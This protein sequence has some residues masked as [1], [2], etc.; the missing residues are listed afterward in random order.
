[1]R[2]VVATLALLGAVGSTGCIGNIRDTTTPRTAHEMLLVSTAAQ[3]AVR[4]YDAGP[5]KGRKV[6]LDLTLFDPIDKN[7]VQSSLRYHLANSGVILSDQA[8]E[9]EIVME[10]RNASLGLWDGDFVLGIPQLPVSAQGLPPVMLPP[11]YAFRRLSHQGFAKFQ[12]WLYDPKTKAYLGRSQDLW[13]TSYYNQWWFFG[14]GPFDGSNDVF[15]DM[16]FGNMVGM[17]GDAGDQEAEFK[18]GDT[19]SPPQEVPPSGDTQSPPR[20]D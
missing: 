9:C 14:I 11:L 20:D 1:M 7:Y 12:L 19:T 13:G 8:S 18:S 10:V 15:P 2:N 3:R 5:L 16:D 6:H 4:L 17:G